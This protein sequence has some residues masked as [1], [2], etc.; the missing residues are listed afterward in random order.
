MLLMPQTLKELRETSFMSN[1]AECSSGENRT[2]SLQVGPR[3]LLSL[4][5]ILQVQS[6]NLPGGDSEAVVRDPNPRGKKRGPEVTSSNTTLQMTKL[7]AQESPVPGPG[8]TRDKWLT[9]VP[10][11]IPKCTLVIRLIQYLWLFSALLTSHPTLKL[12]G[13]GA[14]LP[15][16]QPLFPI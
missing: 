11:N 15:S 5:F 13:P 4:A 10:V 14:S 12:S 7:R 16:P 8:E 6:S 3:S 2:V 1:G 9:V